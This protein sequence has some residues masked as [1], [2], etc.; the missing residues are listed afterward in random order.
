[1]VEY[2][3]YNE[4]VSGSTP[5]LFKM[6]VFQISVVLRLSISELTVKIFLVYIKNI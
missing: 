2:L 5:L 1:M 4:K 6:I 3:A